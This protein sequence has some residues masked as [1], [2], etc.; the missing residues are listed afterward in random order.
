[1]TSVP[2][3][4][5]ERGKCTPQPLA[6]PPASEGLPS[7]SVARII[8]FKSKERKV[9]LD[10]NPSFTGSTDVGEDCLGKSIPLVNSR[11]ARPLQL[12]P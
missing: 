6:S 4:R 3:R 8:V 2:N 11:G 5:G 12:P 1:M 7:C 9:E 10:G